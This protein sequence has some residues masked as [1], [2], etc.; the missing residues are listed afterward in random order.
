MERER[1]L[2]TRGVNECVLLSRRLRSRCAALSTIPLMWE[3]RQNYE[4]FIC[5][6]MHRKTQRPTMRVRL[7][8]G[9]VN[10]RQSQRQPR[11][12]PE[13]PKLLQSLHQNYVNF[14]RGGNEPL[15]IK[16]SC[17]VF[18]GHRL[19]Q[20]RKPPPEADSYRAH[21]LLSVNDFVNYLHTDSTP[22]CPV[23]PWVHSH[24]PPRTNSEEEDPS[25][26]I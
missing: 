17:S 22:I 26:K 6:Y 14:N 1:G 3:K 10:R 16:G 18:L 13:T 5:K 7:W 24:T 2:R 9:K 20:N 12:P 19:H 15:H 23:L 21:S 25:S 11:L 8:A 4:C